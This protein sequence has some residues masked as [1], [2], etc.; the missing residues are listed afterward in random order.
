MPAYDPMLGISEAVDGVPVATVYPPA[1]KRRIIPDRMGAA[2]VLLTQ[3]AGSIADYHVDLSAHLLDHELIVGV[4]AYARGARCKVLSAAYSRGAIKIVVQAG[5]LQTRDIVT[6]LALTTNKRVVQVRFGIVAGSDLAAGMVPASPPVP[7]VPS[8]PQVD[9]QT[10]VTSV[11]VGGDVP[12]D[13]GQGTAAPVFMVAPAFISFG[14][15]DVGQASDPVQITVTNVGNAQLVLSGASVTGDYTVQAPFPL[16]LTPGTSVQILVGFMPSASGARPGSIGIGSNAAGS[17]HMIALSGVGKAVEV[18]PGNPDD[19][20]DP[21]PGE[22]GP[23]A[24][25]SVT[26]LSFGEIAVDETSTAKTLT[27]HNTGVDPLIISSISVAGDF[28]VQASLPATVAAGQNLQIQVRF[29]PSVPGARPGSMLIVSNAPGSPHSVALSGVGASADVDPPAQPGAADVLG[30]GDHQAL[31]LIDNTLLVLNEPPFHDESVLWAV[32]EGMVL[33]AGAGVVITLGAFEQPPVDPPDEP[34]EPEDPDEPVNSPLT[35]LTADGAVLR[36]EAGEQVML[37]SINWYGFEQIGVPAGAWTRP[38]RTK[39]VGGV[40]ME[41]MLDEIKRLGFNSLRVLFSQDCTWPGYKPETRFGYWNTTFIGTELNPEFLNGTTAQDP[42]DVKSTMEIMDLF[43][44]WC[45]E[46]GLRIIFDMHCL[47]PDDNNVLAT[48]GKWYTTSTPTAPGSTTGARR[49]TRNEQQAIDAFVFL[50]DRYK[51]RPVVAGFDLINEPHACTWDRDPVTG[52]VGYYERCGNAI[53]AVNPD[54]LIICEGVSELG[55][56]NGAVDHTP[57][58]HEG[59]PESMQGKYRWGTIWSGKLDEVARIADVPVTLT[60]PNKVVYS[61]H[62]YGSWPGDPA[63]H[64]W[65]YPEQYVGAGYAGLPFPQ[66]MPDV[67]MRQWGYLAEQSIAPVWI[68]EFGSYFRVGGDPI[69]LGGASY[70]QRHLDFD[71]AWMAELADYCNTHSI[72]FA[73]WAW[74]PGGDPDGLVEQN[75]V[76][77]W[78][79]AQQFKLD[80]LEPFLPQAGAAE[81]GDSIGVAARLDFGEVRIDSSKALNL[82][83]SNPL[84]AA[85]PGQASISSGFVLDQTVLNVPAHGTQTLAVTFAPDIEGSRTGS[86]TLTFGTVT[87]TVQLEGAGV[88]A[89]VPP[90]LGITLPGDAVGVVTIGDSITWF[91]FYENNSWCSQACFQYK[92]RYRYRGTR[93]VIGSTSGDSRDSQLPEVLEMDPPPKACVVATGTNNVW[94]VTNGTNDVKAICDALVAHN[95]YPI[96]WTVPPRNDQPAQDGNIL[97]WNNII[98]A[99]AQE[100]GYALVDAFEAWRVAG[101]NRLNAD[102]DYGDGLHP[103]TYGLGVLGKW[104]VDHDAFGLVPDDGPLKLG[105]LGSLNK[106]PNPTFLDANADGLANNLTLASGFQA[107]ITVDPDGTRW[108]RITRPGGVTGT[109]MSTTMAPF[110]VSGGTRYSMACKVRWNTD[111]YKGGIDGKSWTSALSVLFTNEAFDSLPDSQFLVFG[112]DGGEIQ[113]GIV[114]KDDLVAPAGATRAVVSL[115]VL[116]GEDVR[117]GSPFIEYANLSMVAGGFPISAGADDAIDDPEDPAPEVSG[118]PVEPDPDP[119][120]PDAPFEPGGNGEIGLSVTEIDFGSIPKL[121]FK[122]VMVTVTNNTSVLQQ[123]VA[124]AT[125]PIQFVPGAYNVSANSTYEFTV[126]FFPTAAGSWALTTCGF[127]TTTDSIKMKLVGTAT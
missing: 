102:Y 67:W 45:E 70:A 85:V 109:L 105:S 75:P 72:G 19:P 123:I 31:G 42:Q 2:P 50:A 82:V 54:V 30:L 1:D 113:K 94:D 46:L 76:G 116:M 9:I 51:N 121:T 84:G 66:N 39:T 120:D 37:R 88:Q 97:A 18:D 107:S 83:L 58:G 104:I 8:S 87:R 81:P 61:P 41:G 57:E 38:F 119:E 124:D 21:D 56:N 86:I 108:Q 47:A 5:S 100:K 43:V 71:T 106:F 24:S 122:D 99:Y 79:G 127:H 11:D 12:G 33:G 125:A 93:A 7:F 53:H 115:F 3:N 14:A 77:T 110:S 96:L 101:S 26:A 44:D 114:L 25:L 60:A 29:S 65:F 112:S 98:R 13:P 78:H 16:M 27:I 91:G 68:G 89:S 4:R 32:D 95:I 64:Q 34:E 90:D 35:Y 103:N 48:G 49:E 20:G 118:P 126:R 36:N 6:C 10:G 92:Q 69:G 23:V 55:M 73:Y 80:L 74:N 111:G 40:V 59:D 22:G 28:L 63:A 52:V 17:P 15:T 117:N 62:E